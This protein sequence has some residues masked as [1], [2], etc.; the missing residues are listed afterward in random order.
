MGAKVLFYSFLVAILTISCTFADDDHKSI[1]EY[2][3]KFRH[4]N[5]IEILSNDRLFSAYY[6]CFMETGPC[7]PDAR[8]MRG[9]LAFEILEYYHSFSQSEAMACV[10]QIVYGRK[11]D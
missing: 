10:K 1:M 4:I 9:K 3:E 2:L 8:D 5:V 11:G 6:K 7:T